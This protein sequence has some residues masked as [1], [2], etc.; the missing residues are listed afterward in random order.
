MSARRV[1]LALVSFL[2]A[3][4]PL[5]AEPIF[6]SRQYTSARTATLADRGRPLTPYGRSLA[7]GAVDVGQEPRHDA[8]NREQ[9][10][11]LGNAGAR[12]PRHRPPAVALSPTRRA[13]SARRDLLMNADVTAAF[14]HGG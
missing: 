2:A 3:A 11:S 13:G 10:C 4:L 9:F 14:R 1:G 8:K 7:R 6:L 12:E 5:A